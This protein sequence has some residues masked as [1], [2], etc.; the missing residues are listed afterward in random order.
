MTN[1]DVSQALYAVEAAIAGRDAALGIPPPETARP[2]YG[3]D[4]WPPD[5]GRVRAWR[6]QQL[7]WFERDPAMLESAK[8]WY[9]GADLDAGGP[10]YA[11]ELAGRCAAFINHWC[12]TYDPRNAGKPG[13]TTQMPLVMFER[14]EDLVYFVVAC[15]LADAPGLVEKARDM[16]ATWVCLAI[17][18]WLWLFWPGVAIGW[19]AN[20]LDLV[21]VLGDLDTIM[22]RLRQQIRILAACFRPAVVEGVH[23]KHKQCRNPENGAIVSG[24][25]GKQ[26]GRGG[27][28]RLYFV[29]E[30]AHLDRPLAVESSLS[31]NTRCRV[32]V[33]S[34]SKPGTIYHRKRLAGKE[35]DRGGELSRSRVNVFVMDLFSHPE[36][37]REWYEA[38]VERYE[39]QGTPEVVARE[40]D[41]DYMGAAQGI[42]IRREYAEAAVDAHLVLGF[43]DSG[44]WW[45]G[46]DLADDGPD[47]NALVRGRGSVVKMAAE[48]PG[49]DPGTVA[50]SVF[51]MCRETRP[52]TLQY[53]AGG[54]FGG[55]VKS[56]FNRLTQDDGDELD[57]ADWLTLVPWLASAA[58]ADPGQPITPG[59]RQSPT[60]KNFFENFRAQAWWNI[61]RLFYRTW[62]AV[63]VAQR[64]GD[65]GVDDEGRIAVD[66][67]IAPGRRVSLRYAPGE[68]ISISSEIP[69]AAREKLIRE[70]TQATRGE[71]GRL[72]MI[73][74]KAPDGAKSPNLADGLIMGKFPARRPA[75]QR[76]SAGLLGGQIIRA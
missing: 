18:T 70:L 3:P 38:E 71:S 56:E 46:L 15:M 37:T 62:Q 66:G 36:K 25:G 74:N 23:L 39:N 42:I 53:D 61:G 7:A 17:T 52:I 44:P 6:R 69:P 30:A 27:R 13:K 68:L 34:V 10:D 48:V 51:G 59:D 65:L 64:G 75:R 50:R 4:S 24:Q 41:R 40:L 11:E 73:V 32:D 12:D 45:G 9:A 76:V 47:V 5:Y 21:D 28:R 57:L 33:S 8:A 16:G 1:L 43:D 60:N 55:S 29:D 49:R 19:G 72:K 2:P 14:Q 63:A 35:W 22:E 67:E 20:Q 26:M 31:H 58:V 54:G